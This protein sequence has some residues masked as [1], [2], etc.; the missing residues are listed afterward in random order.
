MNFHHKSIK[1]FKL[2]GT[3]YDEAHTDRLK[4]EYLSL[5]TMQMRDSGYV[6]RIDIDYDFTMMYNLEKNEYNFIMSVYGVYVGPK[7]AQQIK[8]VMGFKPIYERADMYDKDM[9]TQ[10]D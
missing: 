6:P 7:K 3:I 9:I 1:K 2:A 4:T 10:G 8:A 5:L